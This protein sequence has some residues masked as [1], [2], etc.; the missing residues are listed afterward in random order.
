MSS[1]G[2][3]SIPIF[4]EDVELVS[5]H[6][7]SD[8][9][10]RSITTV[11]GIEGT[12]KTTLAKLIIDNKEI[13]D[14]FTCRVWMKVPPSYTLELLME[15]TA[16]AAAIQIRKGNMKF[17]KDWSLEDSIF[18]LRVMMGLKYLIVVDGLPTRY[19]MDLLT[20]TIPDMKTASRI[21]LLS[22]N[23]NIVMPQDYFYPLRLL[24]DERSRILLRRKMKVEIP[25]IALEKYIVAK[26][27]GLPMKILKMSKLL[28]GLGL[29]EWSSEL[30]KK[31]PYEGYNRWSELLDIHTNLR[32]M[33]C[34][35]ELY[36]ADLEI[37]TRRLLAVWVA[38]GAVREGKDPPEVAVEGFLSEMINLNML[39]IAKKKANGKPKTCRLLNDFRQFLKTDEGQYVKGLPFR[40]VADRLDQDNINQTDSIH[41]CIFN[42][43]SFHEVGDYLYQC[44]L[45]NCVAR[46]WVLDLEGLYTPN[47]PENISTTLTE[48]KY[49]SL[50]KTYLES[51]PSFLSTLPKLQT[52]DLKHTRIPTLILTRSIW[53]VHLKYLFLT[54]TYRTIFP[55]HPPPSD[56]KTLRGL[57]VDQTTPLK[58]G[59]DQLVNITKLGIAFRSGQ[60]GMESQLDTVADWIANL[61]NLQSLKLKSRDEEGQPWNLHL[62]SLKNHKQL[63]D[64][65][66]LGRLTSPSIL[67]QFPT[68]LS[69]LTLSDSKLEDDPMQILKALPNLRWLSLRHESY[70]GKKLV[71][72]SNSFPRLN[73]LKVLNLK[74]LEELN[75]EEKALRS[76]R[77]LKIRSCPCMKILPRGLEYV[78]NLLQ[79]KLVDMPT[80]ITTDQI[81]IPPNCELLA[82]ALT[83]NFVYNTLSPYGHQY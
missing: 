73:L 21:L 59:L 53:N 64:V 67:S 26:C 58:G 35:F 63:T 27:E 83:S 12:G 54:D 11:V 4:D 31:E 82:L 38:G 49:L 30:E 68:S 18:T 60:E 43:Q 28:S 75:I 56:L 1:S 33:L 2:A 16:K 52:L 10:R 47:L 36:P 17:P 6:L 71:C 81:N 40:R 51:F 70:M 74:H 78:N 5:K 19:F 65:Y 61:K 34:Y 57:F 8:E 39:Q 15:L 41:N 37:P 9:E 72:N 20:K 77:N 48:L 25:S 44:R 22:P 7:L 45:K 62:N 79:L 55:Y 32:E 24:D 29:E 14:R 76:L 80:E 3:V 13:K 46:L 23:A 42:F 69:E 50:R 66:L